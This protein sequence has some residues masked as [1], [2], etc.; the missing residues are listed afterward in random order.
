MARRGTR[1]Q[2]LRR[3]LGVGLGAAAL[4]LGGRA[5]PDSPPAAVEWVPLPGSRGFL[6]P[7]EFAAAVEELNGDGIAVGSRGMADGSWLFFTH[8]PDDA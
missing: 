7:R 1:R 3:A 5:L 6:V 2:F 8:V 4:A